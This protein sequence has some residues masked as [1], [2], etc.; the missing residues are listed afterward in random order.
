MGHSCASSKMMPVDSAFSRSSESKCDSGEVSD[1]SEATAHLE[2]RHCAERLP[3]P[4]AQELVRRPTPGAIGAA[5][6]PGAVGTP[7]PTELRCRMEKLTA[8]AWQTTSPRASVTC[9][10][11]V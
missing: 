5:G 6:A 9:R 1:C 10:V 8:L 7:G 2:R 11:R 3:E 4:A